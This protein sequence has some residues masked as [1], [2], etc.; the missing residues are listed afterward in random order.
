MNHSEI[1]SHK[2]LGKKTKR[3]V[4]WS[5][6]NEGVTELLFFPASMLVARLLTPR[7]FGI[8]AAAGFFTLLAG[9]LSE[10][11]FNAALIRTKELKEEQIS[12]V[13][14]VN[15][16]MGALTFA[17]VVAIAP[18]VS[19]FYDTPEAG[20]IL[21]VAAIGFLIVPFGSIPAALLSRGMRFREQTMV[22]W[23]Q[24]AAFALVTATMAWLGFS[25][26]S[27]VY[28]RLASLVTMTVARLAFTRWRPRLSFSMTALREMF[29][30]GAGVHAKRLLDYT[31][32][33]VDNLVV[34]RLFGMATLG[35]YDKAF[36]TM[37]RC[38]ARLN[39]GGPGVT[40]RVFSV[41]NDQPE[42]FRRAYQKV[43]MSTTLVAFPIFGVLIVVAPRL[44]VVLFG[45]QWLAAA[46]P[47][48]V[49]CIAGCLKLLNT[50]A[51]SAIQS[52]GRVWS[53]VW[54]QA[55]YVGIMIAGLLALR[56]WGAVGAATAVLGATATMAVLMHVLLT[57]VTHVRA[58][59]LVRPQVPALACSA[60][61]IAIVIGVDSILRT[62]QPN[63][64][65][66][67]VLG[68]Q[69]LAA[70]VSYIAFIL[71]APIPRLRSLVREVTEDL[72]PPF[73][74]R[75]RWVRSYLG[76]TGIAE[77]APSSLT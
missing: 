74:Q 43:V 55:A 72:A 60:A 27:M 54:R 44:M 71:F 3:G 4:A 10:L 12:T 42:R 57:R 34:G 33:N 24:T 52:V 37:N 75:H 58:L 32:Q 19:T 49:L 63:A 1:A 65:P 73:I 6:L 16:F 64:A 53:E 14:V 41:I 68:A 29:A 8:A 77:A 31:A 38:L 13:F 50:Y 67:A 61:V 25:Y 62:A 23:F 2:S 7:E 11:G 9:R 17:A 35:L 51:S 22:D 46:A 47:F 36:S 5:F 26:M 20:A 40:F 15:L 21:P 76:L 39:T 56:G 69:A 48:Q 59:D 30:F 45:P 18:L 66:W 28:G 70:M